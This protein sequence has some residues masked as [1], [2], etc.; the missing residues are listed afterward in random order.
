MPRGPLPTAG[1]PKRG[2]GEPQ[3]LSTDS[4]CPRTW[5]KETFPSLSSVS[6]DRSS[7]S[8]RPW[9]E[10]TRAQGTVTAVAVMR[11]HQEAVIS[12]QGGTRRRHTRPALLRGHRRWSARRGSWTCSQGSRCTAISQAHFKHT[13]LTACSQRQFPLSSQASSLTASTPASRRVAPGGQRPRPLPEAR[14]H[15]DLA[16]S[17][18]HLSAP[19]VPS[20]GHY[21]NLPE[22]G[23]PRDPRHGQRF[24]RGALFLAL[25]EVSPW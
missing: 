2:A 22:V 5:T 7:T 14:L 3:G 18:L 12:H 23:A 4:R 9:A 24:L 13:F 11:R 21:V 10:P 17:C 6:S 1:T 15:P 19:P 20:Q 25:R 16:P 8:L